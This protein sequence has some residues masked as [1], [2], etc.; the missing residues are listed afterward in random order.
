MNS[1]RIGSVIG[2]FIGNLV[3]WLLLGKSLMYAVGASLLAAIIFIPLDIFAQK[4]GDKY[5]PKMKAWVDNY[6]KTHPNTP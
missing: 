3:I 2:I 1:R 5:L 6:I 4:A